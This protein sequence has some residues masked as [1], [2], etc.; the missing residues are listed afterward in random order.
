MTANADSRFAQLEIDQDPTCPKHTDVALVEG[1]CTFCEII[2]RRNGAPPVRTPVGPRVEAQPAPTAKAVA[3]KL[4]VVEAGEQETGAVVYW[5][6]SGDMNYTN[7]ETAWAAQGLDPKWLPRKTSPKVALREAAKSLE[8]SERFCGEHPDGGWAIKGK[9][10]S[11][12][13]TPNGQVVANPLLCRIFLNQENKLTGS[14]PIAS[15]VAAQA[16]AAYDTSLATV[17]GASTW[18]VDIVGARLVGT[19]LRPTGGFYFVPKAQK[20]NLEKFKQAI[21]SVS[22]HKVYCIPAMHS[23]DMVEAVLDALVREVS[24]AV[25]AAEEAARDENKGRRAATSLAN[26]LGEL[27]DKVVGHEKLLGVTLGNLTASIK[28]IQVKLME[29]ATRFNQLEVE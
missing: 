20:S 8:N 28:A 29:K 12:I 2:A 3:S 18:L 16:R 17:E 9:K 6:L 1:K 22:S 11:V 5:S 25:K 26:D 10:T 23:A 15:Q 14:G 4:V 21:M 13:D 19:A 7:L 27:A 24:D